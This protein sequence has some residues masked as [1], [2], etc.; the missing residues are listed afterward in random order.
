MIENL[1]GAELPLAA[2]FLIAVVVLGAIVAVIVFAIIWWRASK[3]PK[4]AYV[5][6]EPPVEIARIVEHQT[7]S[8]GGGVAVVLLVVFN[9]IA[10][11]TWVSASNILQQNVAILGWIGWNILWGVGAIIGRKRTY[12][13]FRTPLPDRVE[14][15]MQ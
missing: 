7:F 9:L 15:K 6:P 8:A 11:V 5:P 13:V 14:R 10:V 2:R 3:R 1:F 4:V 12:T